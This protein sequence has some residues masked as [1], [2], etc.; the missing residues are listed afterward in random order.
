MRFVRVEVPTC[1]V[2]W[3]PVLRSC[4]EVINTFMQHLRM[5][6]APATSG[7]TRRLMPMPFQGWPPPSNCP[8]SKPLSEALTQSQVVFGGRRLVAMGRRAPLT[9]RN[10]F[11]A[12]RRDARAPASAL[13]HAPATRTRTGAQAYTSA[14]ACSCGV[15]RS[16]EVLPADQEQA[17]P[18]VA[19]LPR[20]ARPQDS[21]LRCRRKARARGHVP[22]LRAHGQVRRRALQASST[23]D[24]AAACL[25]SGRAASCGW[26]GRRLWLCCMV[27]RSRRSDAAVCARGAR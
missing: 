3:R 13:C 21:Y 25:L 19:L 2:S 27:T 23:H 14:Q 9:R 7:I 20:R 5:C 11:A 18:E 22:V 6:P 17:V 10:C 8:A 26:R 1:A 4:V 24:W 15:C 16:G 12:L